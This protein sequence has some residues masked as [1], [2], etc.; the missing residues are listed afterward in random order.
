MRGCRFQYKLLLVKIQ[1]GVGLRNEIDRI[2]RFFFTNNGVKK[3][4]YF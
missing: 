2:F 3:N 1:S 4:R